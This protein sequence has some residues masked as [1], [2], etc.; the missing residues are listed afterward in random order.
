LR[1]FV[2]DPPRNRSGVSDI[3]SMQITC[4]TPDDGAPL[5]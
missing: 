5:I 3:G 2:N 1:R 4:A